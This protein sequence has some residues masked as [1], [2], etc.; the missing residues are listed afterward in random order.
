MSERV[1]SLTGADDDR[2]VFHGDPPL[3]NR[4]KTIHRMPQ[5]YMKIEKVSHDEHLRGARL[6]SPSSATKSAGMALAC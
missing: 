4:A 5:E 3:R 1:A 6:R 2:V